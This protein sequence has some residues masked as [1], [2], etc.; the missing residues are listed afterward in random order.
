MESSARSLNTEN[1]FGAQFAQWIGMKNGVGPLASRLAADQEGVSR[2][3]RVVGALDKRIAKELKGQAKAMAE[4]EGG[5]WCLDLSGV[6]TWDSEGL[7]ALVYA[8]DVSELNGKQ[9]ALLEPS[10]ALRQTLER[11]QLHHLFQIKYRGE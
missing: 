7:S 1:T 5:S 6:Q 10:P 4:G 2:V 11:A 8:L 9:L 3:I